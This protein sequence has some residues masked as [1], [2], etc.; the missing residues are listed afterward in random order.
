VCTK[1]SATDAPTPACLLL[2]ILPIGFQ[3]AYASNVAADVAVTARP[4]YHI[5]GGQ[6][7]FYAR[8]PYSNPDLGAGQRATRFVGLGS[9]TG[10]T[11]YPATSPGT[12]DAAG[13]GGRAGI[14]SSSA[15]AQQQQQQGVVG[16]AGPAGNRAGKAQPAQK[17]LHA[18]GLP[19]ASTLSTDMLASL[20]DGCGGCPYQAPGQG[21][22]KRPADEVCFV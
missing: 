5:A 3:P 8:L 7:L 16:P 12:A 9:V 2:C 4:R 6:A 19:P 20:P 10:K 13:G 15:A 17:F 18:L 11:P 14:G 22:K 1:P 21:S